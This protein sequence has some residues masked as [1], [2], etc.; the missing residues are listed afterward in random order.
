MVLELPETNSPHANRHRNNAYPNS[1]NFPALLSRSLTR[2]FARQLRFGSLGPL[3][4]S[5]Q[6]LLS[7]VVRG[8]VI[9]LQRSKP[10]FIRSLRISDGR[11]EFTC[12]CSI[13]RC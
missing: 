1:Q 4:R 9:V 12:G 8:E 3:Q 13:R 6:L 2:G 11:T 5:S 7:L 10:R